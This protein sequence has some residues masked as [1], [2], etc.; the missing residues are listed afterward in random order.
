MSGTA[1]EG[2]QTAMKP[3]VMLVDDEECIREI[4]SKLPV[5]EG[6]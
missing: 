1:L 3:R 5:S 2:G 6:I 4:I